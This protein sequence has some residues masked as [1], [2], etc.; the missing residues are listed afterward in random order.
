[1]TPEAFKG[2]SLSFIKIHS[3]FHIQSYL[4]NE[5][6]TVTVPVSPNA[7]A[8]SLVAALDLSRTGMIETSYFFSSLNTSFL[9]I[10]HASPFILP[11]RSSLHRST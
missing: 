9:N 10:T 2:Q 11:T 1:M 5:Y 6:F 3:K 4:T 8:N 7:T